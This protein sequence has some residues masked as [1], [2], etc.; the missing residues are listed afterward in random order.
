MQKV[1][2]RKVILENTIFISKYNKIALKNTKIKIV[3]VAKIED[4]IGE[5]FG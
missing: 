2:I 4:A 5:L 3:K 1:A